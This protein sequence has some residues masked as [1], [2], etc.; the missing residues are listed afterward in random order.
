V[1]KSKKPA[2][3]FVPG[4]IPD[5]KALKTEVKAEMAEYRKMGAEEFMMNTRAIADPEGA[6]DDVHEAKGFAT[7]MVFVQEIDR[8]RMAIIKP[9]VD[10]GQ[11]VIVGMENGRKKRWGITPEERAA[12]LQQWV[13]LQRTRF[14]RVAF[15]PTGLCKQLKGKGYGS[16]STLMNYFEKKKVTIPPVR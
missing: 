12:K 14:P 16:R 3:H 6:R 15:T 2:S 1:S 5:E 13:D 7:A 9:L 8:Q 10:E 11:R 4:G